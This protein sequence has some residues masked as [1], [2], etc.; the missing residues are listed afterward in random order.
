MDYLWSPWRYR[1]VARADQNGECV[2]CEKSALEPARDAESLV[3]FRGERNCV[4]LNL[5]PYTTG[6]TL[7]VPYAH[8]AGTDKADR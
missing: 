5:Y 6:H 7:V 4:L 3:L 2:F 8:I 1:Y